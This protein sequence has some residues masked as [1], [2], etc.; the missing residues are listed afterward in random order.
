MTG[1]LI[2]RI[3]LSTGGIIGDST[4][5]AVTSYIIVMVYYCVRG[6]Y[7]HNFREN[8]CPVD[9]DSLNLYR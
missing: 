4:G 1:Y 6:D 7:G 3:A 2:K 9:F 5:S 8:Q